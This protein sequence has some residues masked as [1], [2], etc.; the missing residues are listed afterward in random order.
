MKRAK[1][2]HR[3]VEEERGTQGESKAR[4][5]HRLK[6]EGHSG[7]G[8]DKRKFSAEWYVQKYGD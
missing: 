2:M 7:V 1:K 6:G 3:R 8:G 5:E 4:D